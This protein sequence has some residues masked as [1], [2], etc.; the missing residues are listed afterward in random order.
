FAIGLRPIDPA[1]WLEG[2][3]PDPAARKDGLLAAHPALVWGEVAGSRPAQAEAL[4]LVA[5]ALGESIE[6]RDAPPLYA[7]ARR[8]PDDL[9]LMEKTAGVWRATAMS[10]SAPTFFTVA[11]VLGR[12]LSELHGP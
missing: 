8:I 5:Q 1:R 4:A 11:G 6:A 9:V 12:D 7:A 3:E 2:G 10:L